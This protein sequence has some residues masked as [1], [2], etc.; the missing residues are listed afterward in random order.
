M[1][2]FPG[3]SDLHALW[4]RIPGASFGLIKTMVTAFLGG[5]MIIT[6]NIHLISKAEIT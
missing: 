2:P 1:T 3:L 5:E 4:D 6:I